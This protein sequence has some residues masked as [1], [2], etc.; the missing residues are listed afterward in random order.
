MSL[1]LSHKESFEDFDY[2]LNL[3]SVTAQLIEHSSQDKNL[4]NGLVN[5]QPNLLN[6]INAEGAAACF[7]ENCTL[8]GKTPVAAEIKELLQWLNSHNQKEIFYT[9]SLAKVYPR[10]EKIKDV[11]SGLLAISIFQDRSYYVLWFRPEV[12]QTVSWG[13]NPNKAVE[14]ADDGSL[15][16]SPRKSFELWKETVRLTSLPW[17]QCEIDAALELRNAIVS[18]VLRQANELAKLNSALQESEARER[19]KATQ[20]EIALK[21][22]QQTQTQL[23]QTEKMASLGQL[24]AGV[25]HEINNPINFIYGNLAHA[26]DYTKGLLTLL[27]LYQARVNFPEHEIAAKAQEIDLDFLMAD[28]PKLLSSMKVGADRIRQIVQALRIFSR[29]DESEIKQVDIHEGIDSTL[30]ILN[31]RLKASSNRPGIEVIK[32]YGKLP[33]IECYA[34]ELNQVFMNIVANAIDA[35]E[36]ENGKWRMENEENNQLPIPQIRIRTE[37]TDNNWVAVRIADNGPGIPEEV[38]GKLFDPFFTTKSVGKGT[39]IGLAIG[40]A[41][42]VE[43][44]GGKLTCLSAPGEG[45]EFIVELPLKGRLI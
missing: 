23:V 42:V 7:G 37:V 17:K 20:L 27:N 32:E 35:L 28:L 40:Y 13:G 2:K 8:I 16:L 44:H 39:G 34:G 15:R 5:Y 36:E 4:V 10:G 29:I 3:K 9:N 21:D 45:A 6:F 18:I 41:V 24:V 38:Q 43:K 30:L 31:N 19:E 14:V 33:K 22:L 12:I 11:A 1:E 25:A 26:E